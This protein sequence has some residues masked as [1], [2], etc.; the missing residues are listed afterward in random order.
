M[1]AVEYAFGC[2]HPESSRMDR[3]DALVIAKCVENNTPYP[4]TSILFT[5]GTHF[6]GHVLSCEW[7]VLK[8]DERIAS[9]WVAM[10][11]EDLEGTCGIRVAQSASDDDDGSDDSP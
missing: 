7:A 4:L 6:V 5:G 8:Y 3:R 11:V 10:D 9:G 1:S 2:R